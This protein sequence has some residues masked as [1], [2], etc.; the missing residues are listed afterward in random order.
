MNLIKKDA[1]E[2]LPHDLQCAY[3]SVHV[4]STSMHKRLIH[5][6]DDDEH[7]F[8]SASKFLRNV[9]SSD[10]YVSRLRHKVVVFW[11]S[12]E[13]YPKSGGVIVKYT[14]VPKTKYSTPINFHKKFYEY[15]ERGVRAFVRYS[16]GKFGI[17][18]YRKKT[19]DDTRFVEAIL[20][21]KDDHSWQMMPVYHTSTYD[22]RLTAEKKAL[23]LAESIC[24]EFNY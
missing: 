10:E 17:E 4:G 7:T 23:E 1:L 2:K 11:F 6:Y 3:V 24:K 5:N 13:P 15:D 18:C 9:L 8:E 22:D 16:E 19:T 12:S 14:A 20:N 21:S